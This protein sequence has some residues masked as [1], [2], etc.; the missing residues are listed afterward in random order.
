[1]NELALHNGNLTA[2]NGFQVMM[3][4]E[5][6]YMERCINMLFPVGDVL[7]IGF[8]LGYSATQIQK[9]P[10]RSHT[11]VECDNNVIKKLREWANKQPHPVNIIHG[12]WQDSMSL[13]GRFDSIF[14][15]DCFLTEHPREHN[16]SSIKYFLQRVDRLHSKEI[17]KIGW[18][19]E[20]PPASGLRNYFKEI[21]AKF[22]LYDFE[23]VK[24]AG[25]GYARKHGD[26][27]FVPLLTLL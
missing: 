26:I 4:W 19:C 18:Y 3:P 10:I 2:K 5:K 12:K 21:G 22:E 6:P 7:E 23:I 25:I 20:D 1:V 27:M 8:G 24:P 9:F 13:L 17:T 15:D 14:F 16:L 11:I